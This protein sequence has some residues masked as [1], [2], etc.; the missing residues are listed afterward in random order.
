MDDA[1]DVC[2]SYLA[3]SQWSGSVLGGIKRY[4]D[5]HA[6]FCYRVGRLDASQGN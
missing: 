3:V 5:C 6:I 2:L 4:Q 1:A